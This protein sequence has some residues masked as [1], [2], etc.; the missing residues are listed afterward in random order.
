M[1]IKLYFM[2]RYYL[3]AT[4][5][6]TFC[7]GN[8]QIINIPDANFKAKLLASA[9]EAIAQGNSG[10]PIIIDTNNDGEIQQS[11]ALLVYSLSLS[12]AGINNL[13]GIEYFTNLT[14][15]AADS[16]QLTSFSQ[17]GLPNLVHLWLQNNNLTSIDFSGYTS[18]QMLLLMNNQI[19][20]LSLNGFPLLW[21]LDCSSNNLTTIDL[22]GCNNLN[23]ILIKNNQLTSITFPEY[24]NTNSPSEIVIIL[25]GNMFATLTAPNHSVGIFNCSNNPNLQYLNIKDSFFP[26]GGNS[27]SQTYPFS[28]CPSLEYI[29]VRDEYISTTQSMITAYGYSNCHVNSYCSFTPGGTYYTL[30]GTNTFDSNNNG[31]DSGDGL[32]PNCMYVVSD[33]FSTSTLISGTDGQFH[34]D[35]SAGT[36]TIT[37]V[38]ENPAA[39]TVSPATASVSFPSAGSPFTQNFCFTPTGVYTDLEVT[40]LPILGAVPGFDAVYKIVFKNKGTQLQNGTISLTY[41][42]NVVDLVSAIPAVALTTTNALQWDFTGLMPFESREII[43]TFNVNSPLETPAV[44]GGDILNYTATVVTNEIDANPANNTSTL[45]QLVVNS[46]DPNDKTCLEGASLTPI[47]IGVYVHYL[48]RFENTGTA[49]AQNIVVKDLIDT[50]KYDITSLLPIS[51]SA[52]FVTRIINT[53]K[54][55]FIFENIDLPFD[56]ATN[57]GYVAFKIKTKPTLL[58]GDSF[59]NTANIYFD[60]NAPIVT[61]TATTTIQ[62]LATADFDFNTVFTLAP[63]PTKNSLSLTAKQKLT[64]SSISIYNALGQLVQVNTNPSET[65]DVSALKTGTYFIKVISEKET[66]NGK[67]IKE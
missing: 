32:I 49:N 41:A 51:G 60:Y 9:T 66:A 11:E 19:S 48:I 67:F 1:I 53:N 59:S 14:D 58:A 27:F 56:D 42:D 47:F 52:P 16:N 3:F 45:N 38:L 39:Y 40:T 2:K 34:N 33:G 30:Q 7:I 37:P 15:L 24:P 26:S 25:E 61:N 55:E 44:N 18:L 12:A 21:D 31:C 20:S 36:Y 29:C 64:I 22:S 54:V 28:N 62:T 17:N 35:V 5:L 13:T 63:V 46:L 23:Q 43:V 6:F 50:N 8:S 65:I 4:L 57:D 10:N